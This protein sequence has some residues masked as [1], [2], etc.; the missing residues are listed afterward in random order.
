M[1]GYSL[2]HEYSNNFYR[3]DWR[4]AHRL[5]LAGYPQSSGCAKLG[6]KTLERIIFDNNNQDS[7]L[8]ND[9]VGRVI[10][11]Y[12]NT[13]IHNLGLTPSQIL[14]HRQLRDYTPSHLEHY[15]LN[16][17]WIITAEHREKKVFPQSI[18]N[19]LRITIPKHMSYTNLQLVCDC[20]A[21]IVELLPHRQ[22]CL[23]M[24]GLEPIC[25]RN[26]RFLIILNSVRIAVTWFHPHIFHIQSTNYHTRSKSNYDWT[27]TSH[28]THFCTY[29]QDH[30]WRCPTPL[31][32]YPFSCYQS[33]APKLTR[34]P[35]ILRRIASHNKP[36][37]QDSWFSFT[38]YF[39]YFVKHD[40]YWHLFCT[41]RGE[42]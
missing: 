3:T 19:W 35:L 10:L 15:K 24:C 30:S 33:A 9:S 12:R 37:L 17:E 38:T 14:F 1:V 32:Q 25:L 5:S 16:K 28:S 8:I 40:R 31:Y 20:T 18:V 13:P 39:C 2:Q 27:S 41:L 42:K 34:I 26:R 29:S 6:V 22:Y 23:K 21:I 11:Q 7:S 36:G 4:I